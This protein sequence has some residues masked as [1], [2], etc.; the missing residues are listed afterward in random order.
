MS[1]LDCSEP[2][3]AAVRQPRAGVQMALRLVYFPVR[4]K[5]E[6]IRMALRYGKVEYEDVSVSDHFGCGWGAGAPPTI[7]T[8]S[9]L[10]CS[11]ALAASSSLSRISMHSM[12]PSAPAAGRVYC[13]DDLARW[14]LRALRGART[15]PFLCGT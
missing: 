8:S 3:T 9:S 13:R 2:K 14:L 7:S 10:S 5:A 1:A 11:A 4:A 15:S 6:C 12:F